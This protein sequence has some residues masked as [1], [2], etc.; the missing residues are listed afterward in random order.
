MCIGETENP[1]PPKHKP[2]S[3]TQPDNSKWARRNVYISAFTAVILLITMVGVYWYAIEAHKANRLARRLIRN[4][5]EQ[6]IQARQAFIATQRA[7]LYVGL[8]SGSIADV[9]DANALLTVHIRNYGPTTA[10]N[11]LIEI[12]PTFVPVPKA[13]QP[14]VSIKQNVPAFQGFP[15]YTTMYQPGSS[16]PPG[17]PYDKKI[18]LNPT[19]WTL[20]ESG[21]ASLF[22]VLRIS[23]TDKFGKYCY[24]VGLSY[25]IGSFNDFH[26]DP[27]PHLNYCGGQPQT[28][29]YETA[30]IT[31]GTRPTRILPFMPTALT[32]P[33][34]QKQ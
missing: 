15:P 6:N 22:V 28:E 12:W 30:M 17:F 23:Y 16:I 2:I 8:P 7:A 1:E 18:P 25:D 29:V 19:Q 3:E 10:E 27:N 14:P 26:L 21:K 13:D 31:V 5:Q 32:T 4:G 20:A 33:N 9:R 24:A 34:P 11:A